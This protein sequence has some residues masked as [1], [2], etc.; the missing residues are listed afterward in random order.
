MLFPG[1]F[2][3]AVRALI[4]SFAGVQSDMVREMFFASELLRAVGTM[5]G[6]LA[7]V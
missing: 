6:S 3:P 5:V 4:G 7:S 1:E 2:L